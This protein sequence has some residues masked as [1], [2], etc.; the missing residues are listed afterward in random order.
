MQ[1]AFGNEVL[2]VSV[3]KRCH[4]MF[5]DSRELAQFE[6]HGGKPTNINTVVTAIKKGPSAGGLSPC[7][8]TENPLGIHLSNSNGSIGNEA[9]VL[10]MVTTLPANG[11]NPSSF[12]Y[13]HQKPHNDH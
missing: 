9:S 6:P 10:S 5:L 4:K 1:E 8:R 3:I 13:L 2:G 7:H 11:R 12:P